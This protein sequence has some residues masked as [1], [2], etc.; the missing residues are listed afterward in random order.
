M[1]TQFCPQFTHNFYSRTAGFFES[2]HVRIIVFAGLDSAR[3][4][5]A[6]TIGGNGKDDYGSGGAR[7][8]WGESGQPVQLLEGETAGVVVVDLVDGVLKDLPCPLRV[9]GVELHA[10]LE[11]LDLEVALPRWAAAA[12]RRRR[13][14]FRGR[15]GVVWVDA[16][17]VVVAVWWT[18]G[19]D[20]A[21]ANKT[22][23]GGRPDDSVSIVIFSTTRL[24]PILLRLVH[25]TTPRSPAGLC[26][27]I[28]LVNVI[29]YSGIWAFLEPRIFIE[30][31]SIL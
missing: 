8:E 11:R 24:F 29:I 23:D 26:K 18:R 4:V 3:Q 31:T 15:S 21:T 10:V 1:T 7:Q 27:Y 5:E 25:S 14:G 16:A 6:A 12:H 28:W 19:E 20:A 9:L 17:K 2:R 30:N 13:V 22:D